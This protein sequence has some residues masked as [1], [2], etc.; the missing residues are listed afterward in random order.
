MMRAYVKQVEQQAA[1]EVVGTPLLL[2]RQSKMSKDN[3][4]S[5]S[6]AEASK[7]R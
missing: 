3:P 5:I 2:D 7:I 4:G 6:Y 1:S